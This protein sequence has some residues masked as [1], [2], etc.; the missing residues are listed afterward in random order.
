M[1]VDLH[2]RLLGHSLPF[3]KNTN[4]PNSPPPETTCLMRQCCGPGRGFTLHVLDNNNVEVMRIVRPFK[5]CAGCCWCASPGGCCSQE[6][7]VEAPVGTVIGYV[8]QE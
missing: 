8:K 1:N 4:I 6:L 2:C 7:Q 3:L 5:C